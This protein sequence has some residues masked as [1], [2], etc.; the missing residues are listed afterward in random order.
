MNKPRILIIDDDAHVSKHVQD[1]LGDHVGEVN[2]ARMPEQGIRLALLEQPDLILLDINMPRMDG[3]KVCRH[4]KEAD[5][6][7]DIPILFLTVEANVE[8]LA[9]AL[10]CG[11]ADYI[12]KPFNEIDLAARVRV[13]LRTKSMIDLLKEQ[14]RIDALTGLGNR[15]AFDTALASSIATW[16]R[17]SQPFSLLLF[18]LDHFKRT[19]DAHGHGVGDELLRAVGA[20]LRSCCRPY[21]TAC[22]LGGDEFVVILGQVQG[23]QALSASERLLEAVRCTTCEFG[24]E[25]IAA[26]CSAGL[27]TVADLPEG[28][29]A[30]DILD[31]ADAALYRAKRNGRDRLCAADGGDCAE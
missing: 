18:D 26:A 12:L 21:D 11:G 31:A 22:R 2:H 29:T 23:A 6:T 19:N 17:G 14:A 27:A 15:T 4:L 9:R 24:D 10:D 8:N 30:A 13:A 3:L 1:L 28:F 20:R 25:R 16:E 7:R 5:A